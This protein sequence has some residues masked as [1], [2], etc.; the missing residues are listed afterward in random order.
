MTT[1]FS[2]VT[3]LFNEEDNVE[4]LIGTLMTSLEANPLV[5]DFEIV[6]VDDGS[7]DATLARLKTHETSQTSVV[8][9]PENSGQSAALAAGIRAAKYEVVGVIDGDLQTTPDDFEKLLGVLVE[10]H[11]FV[12]GIRGD[13]R[14]TRVKKA[15][16]SMANWFR[17]KMLGDSF[18]DIGCPLKVF[19]KECVDRMTLFNSFHRYLP[20]LVELQGF[21]VTEVSVRHFPR[22]AGKTKYGI[23]DRLWIGLQSLYVVRWLGKNYINNGRPLNRR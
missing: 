2:V 11:D 23:F 9:L 4:R 15:S 18:T 14:D 5:A 16:S 21:R 6:C 1:N 3:P 17:R 13:R 12:N 10:G 7:D 22:V 20:H 8:S 19:R